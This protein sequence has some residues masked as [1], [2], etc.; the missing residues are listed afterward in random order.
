MSPYLLK[1]PNLLHE[2]L[3]SSEELPDSDEKSVDDRLQDLL[4]QAYY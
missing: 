1:Q 2:N 3:P 4:P